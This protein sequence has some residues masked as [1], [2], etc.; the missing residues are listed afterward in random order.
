MTNGPITPPTPQPQM[1]A[2]LFAAFVGIIDQ[3]SVQR[4]IAGLGAAMANKV[5]RVHLLFQST[6]GTVGDGIRLYNFLYRLPVEISLYNIG[7]VASIGALAYLGAKIRKTSPSATFMLHRTQVSPGGATEER[8]QALAKN[9]TLD[10]ARTETILRARLK[11]PNDLWEMHK[12]ADLWL[13]AEEAVK[14]GLATEIGEFAP[15]FGSQIFNV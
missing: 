13:S 6:G 3:A 5:Q 15:P 9:V 4:I 11:L 14:Y 12:V 8:L 10:D 7:T 1:P 2:E